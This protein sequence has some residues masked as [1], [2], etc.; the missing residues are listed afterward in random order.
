MNYALALTQDDYLLKTFNISPDN[1]SSTLNDEGHGVFFIHPGVKKPSG[2][3]FVFKKRGSV[4]LNFSIRKG[5][6]IGNIEFTVIKNGKV[7]KKLIVTAQQK[8][9]LVVPV[10]E[11]DKLEIWAD[12]HGDIAADWGNLEIKI[13]ESAFALKNFIIPF[14]WTLLFIFLLGKNHKY[15]GINAY[16]GFMLILFAEKLN[17][18]PLSFENIL[19]YMLFLFAMT[20]LF[21]LFYQELSRLKRYKVATILSY[22]SA[23]SIYI[24]PLFFI[25]Y[26]LNYDTAV[27]RDA[28]FAI[29]QSNP[30][31]SIEY[32]S[33]FIALKY[34]V[35]FIFITTLVGFLLYR[36]EKKETQRIEKSL[37]VFLILV[38]LSIS[39]VQFSSLKLPYFLIQG[40]DIYDYELTQFKNTLAKRKTG[41]I[42]FNATKEKQGETYIVIIGESLNKR[43]MGIYGYMRN[44]T[45]NL[46]KMNNEGKLV[47]F[48][49]TYSNHTHTVP[50]LE[51]ALTEANQY[52]KK[53]FFNSLS[54]IDILKKANIET[55]WLT[56]QPLYSMYDNMVSII[57]TSADHVVALNT[58]IGGTVRGKPKYDAPLI[59]K[60]KKVLG[61]KSNKSKVI[62]VHLGG[63]HTTYTS[64]YPNDRYSI[65]SGK[66]NQ[67]E[68]GEK[69]SKVE[70]INAYDNSVF[71]NDYVVSSIL[72]ALQNDNSAY[73]FIYMSDHTDDVINK[74]AHNSALFTYYMTQV[75]ML[76]WFSDT[77]KKEYP[78]KYNNLVQRT[79][80][81]FS[82]D[83]LYNTM[84][85]IFGV[86]TDRY[87]SKYDFSSEN[88]KLNPSDA[89]VLH[90]KK[91]YTDKS[92]HLY[93]QK[94]NSRYLIDTNQSSRIFPHCVDSI[95]KLKDI[96][97][98]G[99]RSFE[100]DVRFGEEN[101]TVFRVGST[102]ALRGV[103]FEAFLNR[104]ENDKIEH[105][106]IDIK[107]L[108]NKNYEDALERLSYLD[109][110]YH[111]KNRV[112][113]QSKLKDTFIKAFGDKGWHTS[114][115]L[116][117]KTIIKLLN[118]KDHKKM[119]NLSQ[120]IAEQISLQYVSAISFDKEVYGWVKEYLEP[121]IPEKIIYHLWSSL[122]LYDI[123][124]KKKLLNN[125]LYLD[126]RVKTLLGSY[127]SQF[128]L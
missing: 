60:V 14:L 5:S 54:I 48:N 99:F 92:N 10:K 39:S 55:Y 78:K 41:E 120:A 68:F 51:L 22:I 126:E 72:K 17:F 38:F 61:K 3:I 43:H 15:I 25:I 80:T 103:V 53:T 42:Q 58:N 108:N 18:G 63:S 93:W 114:Y 122:T 30:D 24:I 84:I 83:M 65:F 70:T 117:T 90:G 9:Q 96:W 104:I 121:K 2:G 1:T 36:Q 118:G 119:E 69:A 81:L 87:N 49:N 113:V 76:A 127:D 116:P 47:L 16:I 73:A 85:G 20:F 52:N 8:Q 71:Y 35:L 101:A 26:A 88:Y 98:E 100:V 33:D 23:I 34:I 57:G 31:E 37:L 125:K 67:G 64:R 106:I 107:N 79:E 32:I 59:D 4:I 123:D 75:P 74:V 115:D 50:V 6:Q 45:P 7:I 91:H 112:L 66:L 46:S 86:K 27:T 95:G 109:E 12:K 77:F 94:V 110:K 21:T 89:L 128:E 56:N 102:Q 44:T 97:N 19:T 29:F 13:Q 124:C 11:I 105:M 28:L 40:F 62:F 82:N 111:L